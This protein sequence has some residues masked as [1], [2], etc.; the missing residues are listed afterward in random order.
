MPI[1]SQ[2]YRPAVR[3][4]L[5]GGAV[6]GWCYG[7]AMAVRPKKPKMTDQERH[8]RFVDMARDLEASEEAQDFDKAFETVTQKPA[9]SEK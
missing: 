6:P 3:K 1:L 8:E 2:P 9:S 4:S 7:P 5:T